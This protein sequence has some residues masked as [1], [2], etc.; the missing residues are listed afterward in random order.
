MR[1][2]R[3]LSVVG[4][5]CS[6]ACN[7]DRPTPEASSLT[8]AHAAALVD[9]VR[10]FAVAVARDVTR[11][12]PAAWQGH[13]AR[14]PAFFMAAEGRVVFPT[15]DAATRGIEELRRVIR[16]IELRWEDSVRVDPLAPGLAALAAPYHEVRVDTAGKRVE[17]AG[18]FTGLV[19]HGADGWQLRDAHWSVAG[20]PPPVR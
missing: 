4:A 18:Y 15:S 11:E 10:A 2:V 7:R 13:F 19:E 8:P 20:A 14:S 1:V 17:E 3:L 16:H 9:S 6:A 12:G 5:V